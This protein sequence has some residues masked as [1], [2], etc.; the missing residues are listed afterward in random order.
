[1]VSSCGNAWSLLTLCKGCCRWGHVFA[2]NGESRSWTKN[3]GCVALLTV[4]VGRYDTTQN[5]YGVRV[6]I[7]LRHS[8]LTQFGAFS[9]NQPAVD[10]MGKREK[11]GWVASEGVAESSGRILV[12]GIEK[13]RK[14]NGFDLWP[15]PRAKLGL[16]LLACAR[17][18]CISNIC[19]QGR[20]NDPNDFD[21]RYIL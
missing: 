16:W 2:A 9:L 18:I 7:A 20:K 5:T 6:A 3:N 14:K 1:M 21:V 8:R 19:T 12:D 10:G 15:I 13:S 4:D 11:K 17:A